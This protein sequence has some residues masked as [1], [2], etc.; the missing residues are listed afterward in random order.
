MW[1]CLQKIKLVTKIIFFA[2]VKR[3]CVCVCVS[4]ISSVT[5]GKMKERGISVVRASPVNRRPWKRLQQYSSILRKEREKLG[6]LHYLHSAHD[7]NTPDNTS[8]C[9]FTINDEWIYDCIFFHT[10]L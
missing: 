8:K 4:S 2:Q 7:V 10:F 9:K 3:V 5:L 1:M 6:Q